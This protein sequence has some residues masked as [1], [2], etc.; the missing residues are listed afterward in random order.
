MKP[1]ALPDFPSAS[2][3]AEN[4]CV[5]AARRQAILPGYLH[6][7]LVRPATRLAL[8]AYRPTAEDLAE[9]L[10]LVQEHGRD[11]L[12]A[13]LKNATAGKSASIKPRS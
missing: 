7:L 12:V 2:Q 8:L 6:L 9:A 4:V 3:V 5:V 13:P 1:W 10:A 11:V